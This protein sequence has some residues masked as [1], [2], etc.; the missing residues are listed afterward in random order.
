MHISLRR[1]TRVQSGQRGWGNARSFLSRHELG[2]PLEPCP[3]SK[4]SGITVG[5]ARGNAALMRLFHA[6]PLLRSSLPSL[7]E[8]NS[9]A[10][11]RSIHG[12][13]RSKN[14]E[15]MLPVP[16]DQLTNSSIL[17]YLEM[18]IENFFFDFVYSLKG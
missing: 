15:W 13:S 14:S 16:I 12:L 18:C 2:L 17:P 10:F 5:L 3:L 7:N 9:D 1:E 11:P 4:V 8:E 6:P